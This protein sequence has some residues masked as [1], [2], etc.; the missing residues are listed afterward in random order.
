MISGGKSDIFLH[1]RNRCTRLLGVLR[2]ALIDGEQCER[3]TGKCH[4]SAGLLFASNG[5]ALGI[6]CAY[7]DSVSR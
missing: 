7:H 3:Y 5:G 2:S 6:E 1:L 4:L